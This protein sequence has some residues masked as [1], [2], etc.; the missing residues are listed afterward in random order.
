MKVVFFLVFNFLT[1]IV[2]LQSARYVHSIFHGIQ[3][4]CTHYT[5]QAKSDVT[6][7]VVTIFHPN[8]PPSLLT[9]INYKAESSD[10]SIDQQGINK[11]RNK[12]FQQLLFKCKQ[13]SSGN[14]MVCIK[15][16]IPLRTTDDVVINYHGFRRLLCFSFGLQ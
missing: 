12:I 14:G 4:C 5:H 2:V 3:E 11:S 1:I 15:I 8:R 10:V 16:F 9:L 13:M 6:V 7:D